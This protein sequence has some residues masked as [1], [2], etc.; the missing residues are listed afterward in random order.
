ME[1]SDN[2]CNAADESG[3]IWQRKSGGNSYQEFPAMQNE[4]SDR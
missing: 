2:A 3:L 4:G 1:V